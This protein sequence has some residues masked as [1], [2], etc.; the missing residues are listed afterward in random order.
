MTKMQDRIEQS[1]ELRAPIGR[2]WEALTDHRQFGEWFRVAIDGPFE[3]GKVSTGHIT[4]P[5]YEHL[6]W[7]ATVQAME[8]ERRFAYTWHPGDADPERVKGSEPPTLVEF[9]LE[10]RGTGTHL[11]VVESGFSRLPQPR[12][13]DAL[14]MNTGGWIEQM[15]NVRTYVDG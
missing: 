5:G 3:V 14:R 9:T 4:Y 12:A 2:V 6:A 7:H 1:V 10:P 15:D 8:P 11:T 13:M